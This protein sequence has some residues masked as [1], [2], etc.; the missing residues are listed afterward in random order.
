MTSTD[1]RLRL[2][3]AALSSQPE[4]FWVTEKR[5][6]EACAR[7]PELASRLV[8]DWSWDLV[9]FKE[10]LPI[11]DILIGWRF[12][13]LSL[14]KKSQHLKW[15]Q[16][17]GAG[18]EHLQ[19]LNWLPRHVT[20][21]NN[22]G[23]HASKLAEFAGTAVLMLNHGFPHYI[24]HQRNSQWSKKFTTT[25]LGKTALIIGFGNTG[26][27]V[28][29]WLKSKL[30]L[31]II[32]VRRTGRTHRYADEMFAPDKLDELLPRA[33]F[34]I[35]TAPL[36]SETNN[37]IDRYR[38]SLLK[39]T[40]GIVNLG[41]AKIIDYAALAEFLERGQL[42]GAVLDVFDPEPLP[43]SSPL[44]QT[45]NLIAVPHCSSDDAEHYIAHTLDLFFKN[46]GKLFQGKRLKNVVSRSRE[47]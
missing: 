37:L 11:S 41:R 7:H 5:F 4:V 32:G 22:A 3:I 34:V 2:H 19:P 17:T 43:S 15:I 18:I 36:T 21:T 14:F 8:T 6:N 40:A 35:V 13:D 20:L 1:R 25:I 23:V 27:S 10:A 16:L 28:A 33:D 42:A 24:T 47:Y 31:N 30:E 46:L 26:G 12:D 9:G 39:P 45:R 29:R 38:L 44:W